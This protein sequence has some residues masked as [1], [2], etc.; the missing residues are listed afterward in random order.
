V[1][2]ALATKEIGL[3]P[4]IAPVGVAAPVTSLRG[5]PGVNGDDLAAKSFSFILQE[6]LELGEAPG[7]KPSFS[8]SP[9]C[10]HSL[11]DVSE[12]FYNDSC[13]WLNAVED[14]GGQNVVAIPSEALLTPSEASKMPFSGLR[15]FGLEST[16][17]AKCSL[18]NFLHMPVAVKAVVR[19]NGGPGNAQVNAESLAIRS[20]FNIG[21]A[22]N[23]VKVKPAWTINKISC[24]CR[25]ANRVPGIFRKGEGYF[26]SALSGR[27]TDNSLVPVYFEGVKVIPGRASDRLRAADL[28]SLFVPADC[29]PN[30]LAGFM[31]RL[32]MQIGDQSRQSV[33]AVAIGQAVKRIGVAGS[34]LP[35]QAT[36]G[37]ISLG[38]LLNRLIKSFSL[39][40][41]RLK[42]YT[43]RSIHI[44]IIPHIYEYLQG[45]EKT[46]AKAVKCPVCGGSG[47]VPVP[48]SPESS[49]IFCNFYTCHGCGGKGWIVIPD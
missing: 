1:K 23:N 6:F 41:G 2:T 37:V 34:L 9:G 38:K 32:Y 35:A 28:A 48:S 21:Q 12:V 39:F 43:Y 19:S 20:K 27:K 10:L 44:G 25:L 40:L 42:L 8:L 36:D 5:M 13:A 24:G 16:S 14:R 26:H 17:E 30:R 49:A 7:V 31:Y 4:A 15:T 11:P 45:S 3:R 46:M 22:N 47:Q 33:F 18:D 29:R